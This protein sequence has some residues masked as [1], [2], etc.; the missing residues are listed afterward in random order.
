MRRH[1]ARICDLIRCGW[2]ASILGS[3]C[4]SSTVVASGPDRALASELRGPF[5]SKEPVV[6]L[7]RVPAT[8]LANNLWLQLGWKRAGRISTV[9]ENGVLLRFCWR[10]LV[11][12]NVIRIK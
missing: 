10:W 7:V 1:I 11:D 8:F 12:S 5:L 9:A 4:S 2:S 6:P 3:F